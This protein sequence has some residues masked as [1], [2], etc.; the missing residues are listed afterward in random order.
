MID[1]PA[2]IVDHHH[3]S[4]VEIG[5]P[6]VELLALFQDEYAHAL[7]RQNDR[8]EGVCQFV[9]VQHLYALQLRELVEVEVVSD[10]LGI[11]VLSKLNQLQIHFLE[12]R[13]IGF[14]NPHVEARHFL[15]LLQNVQSPPAAVPFQT[16]RRVGH[17]LQ[18]PKHELRNHQHSVHE[19]RRGYVGDAA[20]DDHAGV[21]ELLRF[22]ARSILPK[23]TAQG[24]QVEC[25]SFRAADHHSHVPQQQQ[26]AKIDERSGFRRQA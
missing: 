13:I 5:H 12:A 26:E 24:G 25:F 17:E 6:L 16:V 21:E 20:V 18:L 22:F 3:R 11:D 1:E 15:D 14:K 7:A 4:V 19:P 8:L 9:D 2:S 23:D 10:D